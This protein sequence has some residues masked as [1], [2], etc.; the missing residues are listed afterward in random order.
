MTLERPIFGVG[1]GNFTAASAEDSKESGETA[2][3]RNTHNA[4]TQVSSESGFPGLFL[5]LVIIAYCYRT[6]SRIYREAKKRE[7]SDIADVAFCFRLMIVIYMVDACFDSNAYL[8]HLPVFSA[9]IFAF[10]RA[11]RRE[12]T[13]TA[14]P[15]SP[16]AN[17]RAAD[18][19]RPQATQW[20]RR[21]ASQVKG[22]SESDSMF[23]HISTNPANP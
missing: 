14:V 6:S 21:P 10:D 23:T 5:F 20:L 18:D 19:R 13:I 12:M 4:Y 9:M 3:W 16:P 2:A 22:M 15:Q 17:A 1:P 7:W 8:Y 11:V